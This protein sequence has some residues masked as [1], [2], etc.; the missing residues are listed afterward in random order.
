MAKL[1]TKYF[2]QACGFES[3]KWAGKCNNCE[4]WNTFVEELVAKST[5]KEEQKTS[6]GLSAANGPISISEIAFDEL[7]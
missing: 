5:K 1:K 6:M 4:E 3:P 2:C 7:K